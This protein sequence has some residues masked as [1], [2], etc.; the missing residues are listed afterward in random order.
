MVTNLAG[1]QTCAGVGHHLYLHR[2]LKVS[3]VLYTLFLSHTDNKEIKNNL[4]P[5]KWHPKF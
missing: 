5:K 1:L 2:Y 4:K 3:P